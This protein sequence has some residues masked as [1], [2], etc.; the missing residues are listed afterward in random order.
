MSANSN[1]ISHTT[2][3]V[4]LL[5]APYT[6]ILCTVY[7]VRPSRAASSLRCAAF[8]VSLLL[9]CSSTL[10]CSWSSSLL[11]YTSGI[12]SS[13]SIIWAAHTLL[14]ES[15]FTMRRIQRHSD[16]YIWESMPEEY[17]IKRFYWS[18]DLCTNFRRIG[19]DTGTRKSAT[20][21]ATTAMAK[22]QDLIAMGSDKQIA[23]VEFFQMHSVTLFR[24]Y[25]LLNVG[26]YLACIPTRVDLGMLASKL[27][28]AMHPA[29]LCSRRSWYGPRHIRDF[30]LSALNLCF[31][32]SWLDRTETSRPRRTALDV[33]TTLWPHFSSSEVQVQ[34]Y[35]G[36]SRNHM[37][38]TYNLANFTHDFDLH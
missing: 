12:F 1:C 3:A 32:C 31:V 8:M 30:H 6:L 36:H 29:H 33:S 23:P 15:P 19:W 14:I 21:D 22:A 28:K 2:L 20:M 24:A 34:R 27:N 35:V 16:G 18:L 37:I 25:A 10:F 26:Q 17:A 11:A 4:C 9:S 38:S 7:A 13:W 5:A